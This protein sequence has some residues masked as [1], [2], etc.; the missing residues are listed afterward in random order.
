MGKGKRSAISV[1]GDMII[2]QSSIVWPNVKLALESKCSKKSIQHFRL[3][4]YSL[5]HIVQVSWQTIHATV[6]DA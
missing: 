2:I 3:I 4:V 1:H 5:D 6:F